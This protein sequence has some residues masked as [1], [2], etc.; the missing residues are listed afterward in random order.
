MRLTLNRHTFTDNTTIG[1]LYL[2]N[3]F[4][5]YILEDKDRWPDI[6][7]SLLGPIAHS[8]KVK[9]ETCIPY[10]TFRIRYTYSPK[11]KKRMLLIAG[12]PSFRG[13]RIHSGN[14]EFDTEGCPLP[15][16]TKGIDFVGNSRKA[17]KIVEDLIV[18]VIEDGE[19]VLIE[20]I[21][22]AS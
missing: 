10:G 15:G 21:K 5:C 4:I 14:D 19:E 16:L 6:P 7:P 17:T 2:V 3:E 18:P 12:V 9:G 20:I 8:Y 13:I 1:D 11:Y 22:V